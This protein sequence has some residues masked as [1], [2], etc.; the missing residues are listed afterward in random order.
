MYLFVHSF[1]LLFI[2]LF[3][4]LFVG[5]M[6]TEGL[7]DMPRFKNDTTYIVPNI[8]FEIKSFLREESKKSYEEESDEELRLKSKFLSVKA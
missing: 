4:Y 5:G 8:G 6:Q 2:Y 1:I 7:S 3:I